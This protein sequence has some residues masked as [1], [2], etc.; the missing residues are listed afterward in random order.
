MS[1]I[2]CEV[3]EKNG[4]KM[5]IAKFVKQGV[6]LRDIWFFSLR[7]HAFKMLRTTNVM[8]FSHYELDNTIDE[9]LAERKL[10]GIAKLNDGDE[11]DEKIGQALAREDLKR[12]YR[13]A[14]AMLEGKIFDMINCDLVKLI[15][16]SNF[17]K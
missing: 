16:R 6:T 12:R 14:E 15:N 2:Q 17:L 13:K 11:F 10:V 8:S 7:E 9:I 3:V 5:T 4:K 1:M